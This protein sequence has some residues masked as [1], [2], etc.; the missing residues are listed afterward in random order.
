MDRSGIERST[1]MEA[2]RPM[3]NRLQTGF[4][5]IELVIVIVIV[6]ILASVALP[7]YQDSIRKGRRSDAKAALFAV[8]GRQEQFMLDR[9]TY[10]TDMKNLGYTDSASM[11]SD[12][13]HYGIVSAACAGGVIGN[14]YALTAT[15]LSSSPQAKDGYCTSFTLDSAGTKSATGTSSADCW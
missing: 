6:A 1:D 7:S 2:L 4:T 14:C 8:A 13:G 15:P 9:G 5:L 3:S 11:I 10:T 12:E